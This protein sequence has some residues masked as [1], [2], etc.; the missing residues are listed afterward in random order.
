MINVRTKAHNIPQHM[1]VTEIHD[2]L[3]LNDEIFVDK[4]DHSC[5]F[6]DLDDKKVQESVFSS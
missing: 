2:I 5:E 6:Y 3:S 1:L 4:W